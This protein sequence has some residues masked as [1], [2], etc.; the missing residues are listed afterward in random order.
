MA[1]TITAVETRHRTVTE[2]IFSWL[3]HTTGAA[4]ATATTYSYSGEIIK[5]VCIPGATTPSDLYD[6]TLSDADSIDLLAGQ[7]TDCPSGSSLVITGG[8]LPV[9]ESTISLTIA[10]GG[11]EKIGTVHVYIR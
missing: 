7:G 3:S 10:N 6:V 4:D 5:V 2:I 8:I 11:S 9:V 1:G